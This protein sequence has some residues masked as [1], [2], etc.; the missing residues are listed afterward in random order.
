MILLVKIDGKDN[1][2]LTNKYQKGKIAESVIRPNEFKVVRTE[3]F[4]Y[5]VSYRM[6]LRLAS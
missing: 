1:G 2:P 5:G 4:V 6:S 3:Q